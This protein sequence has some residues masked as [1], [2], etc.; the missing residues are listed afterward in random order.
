MANV[1]GANGFKY[2]GNKTGPAIPHVKEGI[3]LSGQTVASGDPLTLN[4][5]VYSIATATSGTIAAVA[6][7]SLTA[8]GN[9]AFKLIPADEDILFEVQCSGT[10]AA[11]MEGLAVDIEGTTG[12]FEANEDATTL[13]VFQIEALVP[14][15]TNAV[16]ANARVYGRFLQRTEV[17]YAL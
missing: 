12:V 16:G 13:G 17:P 10:Y 7:E 8:S 9:T 5:G 2:Y 15:S 4:S 1:D 6:C 11:S 3:L 14:R